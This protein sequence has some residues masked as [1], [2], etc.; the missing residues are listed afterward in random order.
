MAF[1]PRD[2]FKQVQEMQARMAQMQERLRDVRVTGT[3]GGEMVRVEID[4][5]FTVRAVSIAPE[6]VDPA[7]LRMLEDL[8]RAAFSDA[9]TR[10]KDR[11]REE[12]AA[13]TGG[14]GIP[15]GMLGL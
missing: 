3:A 15:P 1:N 8:V 9:V 12:T 5:Q 11:L 7:D 14:M 4:G 6:A 2:L 10:L 13:L